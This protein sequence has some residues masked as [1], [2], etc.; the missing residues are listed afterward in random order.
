MSGGEVTNQ[1]KRL[2]VSAVLIASI[3]I[4]PALAA[5]GDCAGLF[6]A[7]K[8]LIEVILDPAGGGACVVDRRYNPPKIFR[9]F[10]AP[11]QWHR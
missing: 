1:M 8:G 6:D 11:W 10:V 4:H 9:R 5:V 7:Q 2:L 3:L